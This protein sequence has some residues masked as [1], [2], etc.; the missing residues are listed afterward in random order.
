MER[1][2]GL[3]NRIVGLDIGTTK[4]CVA[5]AEVTP[6]GIDIRSITSH[7]SSGLRKG[8]VIDIEATAQSIKRAVT[9]AQDQC[10]APIRDVFI[11]I[12]GNHVKSFDSHGAVGIKGK[13]VS[14]EDV[15]RVIDSA[16]AVYMPLDR[17]IL[18]VLPTDFILDGQEGL[19]DPVGMTGVRL[20]VKVY[21][22]TGAVSAVQNLVK[23]CEKAGLEVLDIVLQ[24]LASGEASLSADERDRGIALIDSGGGTTDIALYKDGWLRHTAVL[25]IGGN[26]FTND[27]SVGLRLPLHEAERIKKQYGSLLLSDINSAG[28]IQVTAL[29]GQVRDIPKKYVTEILLP[30][31]EELIG[32]VRQ[33]IMAKHA[34][35]VPVL[36]AVLTGGASLLTGFDR[37]TES[38]LSMPVRI[39]YPGSPPEDFLSEPG[40][41]HRLRG[42]PE[43]FNNP[44]YAT[45]IGL[46]RYGAETVL[47]AESNLSPSHLMNKIVHTM[48]GWFRKIVR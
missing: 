10:A 20:E 19:K 42:L 16:S 43:E 38:M 17:E 33:E 48:T 47:P 12:A 30:R 3:T 36:G 46:V 31:S 21:I 40:Q 37:L 11:G 2:R 39:G 8:V 14:P 18:H 44:M 1:R 15:E 22:V 28:Q 34:S 7:P 24:P 13:E 23:C 26:H 4:I 6:E 27:L 35:G 29:D 9:E 41:D 45:A 25:G 32:L 5:V